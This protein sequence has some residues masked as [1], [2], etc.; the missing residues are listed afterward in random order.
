MSEQTE[1]TVGR[2]RDVRGLLRDM[3]GVLSMADEN[4]PSRSHDQ[5]SCTCIFCHSKRLVAKADEY[6]DVSPPE[7]WIAEVAKT[8]I[9]WCP[10]RGDEAE[11]ERI[12][13]NAYVNYFIAEPQ[14]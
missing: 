5:G 1:K 10:R 14:P 8:I 7:D 13:R 11:V 6:L 9:Q 4:V 2:V 12:I 3:R